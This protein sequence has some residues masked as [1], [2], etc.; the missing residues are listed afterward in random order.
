V[1]SCGRFVTERRRKRITVEELGRVGGFERSTLLG[2]LD[3][4]QARPA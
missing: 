2:Y 1:R 3:D 4:D